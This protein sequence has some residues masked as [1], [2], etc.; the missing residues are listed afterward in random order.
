MHPASA[1]RLFFAHRFLD[2]FVLWGSYIGN[3]DKTRKPWNR[4]SSTAYLSGKS[5]LGA[6]DIIIVTKANPL[7]PPGPTIVFVN[8]AFTRLTGYTAEEALGRTP[9]ILQGKLTDKATKSRIKAALIKQVPIKEKIL[10]YTKTGNPY[11]LDI[12]L[13]PLRNDLGEVTHFAAIERDIT[14]TVLKEKKLL[15][16]SLTDA[17]TGLNNR[18]G[19]TE[20]AGVALLSAMKQSKPMTLAMID[21]DHFKKVNDTFGH[22]AGDLVLKALS[23][24]FR[25]AFRTTDIVGRLGGEEF[26]L[27][28]ADTKPVDCVR[29]LE[30]LREKIARTEGFHPRRQTD[31]LHRQFWRG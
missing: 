18:R 9:R 20:N 6:N 12:S 2:C 27:L 23:D 13:V 31:P 14:E 8:E 1:R 3:K 28:L 22:E 30:R 29:K 19:F 25:G 26:V 15:E 4:I 21:I 24:T 5:S 16:E 11:W 17:L 7:D 10:N